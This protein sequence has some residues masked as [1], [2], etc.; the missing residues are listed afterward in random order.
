MDG[1][2]W[3]VIL[4]LVAGAT[5]AWLVWRRGAPRSPSEAAKQFRQAMDTAS[6]LTAA[7]EQLWR[8]GELPRDGRL[9]Y[10]MEELRSLYPGLD[11]GQLRALVEAAVFLWKVGLARRER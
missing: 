5:L 8:T 11:E 10:V 7:A 6:V 3:L 4:A 1:L 2:W 9:D